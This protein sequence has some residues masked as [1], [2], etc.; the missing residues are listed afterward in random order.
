MT[1][2]LEKVEGAEVGECM[3]DLLSYVKRE[4]QVKDI[5]IYIASLTARETDTGKLVWMSFRCVF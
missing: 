3:N 5:Y 2:C 1:V 4:E